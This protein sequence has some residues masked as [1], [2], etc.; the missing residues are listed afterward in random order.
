MK[1]R[2]IVGT[3]VVKF[4]SNSSFA[5]FYNQYFIEKFQTLLCKRMIQ[6]YHE[7]CGGVEIYKT[8]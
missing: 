8:E 2:I 6:S 7:L 3:L 1:I 5:A 4:A